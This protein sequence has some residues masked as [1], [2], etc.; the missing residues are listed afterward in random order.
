MNRGCD[1]GVSLA[2]AC[3]YSAVGGAAG[4]Q[5]TAKF[6]ARDHVEAISVFR[7]H[8]ED[9]QIGIGFDGITNQ[10]IQRFE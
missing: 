2:N 4:F 8:L 1:F 10:W 9:P 6:P 7:N 5:D 3:K